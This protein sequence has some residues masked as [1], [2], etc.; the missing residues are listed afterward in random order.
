MPITS[1]SVR[2]ESVNIQT[3]EYIEHLV[4]DGVHTLRLT[5]HWDSYADQSWGRIARWNGDQWHVVAAINGPALNVNAKR[6]DGSRVWI[7]T[8]RGDL[9]KFQVAAFQGDRQHLIALAKEVL[10]VDAEIVDETVA[11]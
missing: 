6:A 1:L 4:L 2:L 10:V 5:V 7:Y 9:G 11:S 3:T 8:G